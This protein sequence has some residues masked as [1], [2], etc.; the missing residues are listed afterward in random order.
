MSMRGAFQ[1]ILLFSAVFLLALPEAHAAENVLSLDRTLFMQMAIFIA[2]IFLLDYLLFKPLLEL[3]QRRRDLTM[4]AI[5]EAQELEAKTSS[6]IEDY[7]TRIRNARA[8]FLRERE[9]SKRRAQVEALKIVSEARDE[10][11]KLIEDARARIEVETREI[12]ERLRSQ[13]KG[14]ARE[15]TAQIL[16]RRIQ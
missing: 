15:I 5:R 16:G 4:G 1:F 13:V 10:A 2:A 9:E 11:Q 3:S 12:R 7:E 8:S 14:I 6:L